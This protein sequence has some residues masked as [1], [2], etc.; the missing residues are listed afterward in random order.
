MT[1]QELQAERIKLIDA[2]IKSLQN[3]IEAIE[4]HHRAKLI[5]I[6]SDI[7]KLRAQKRKLQQDDH[8]QN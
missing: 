3:R 6:V 4:I 1:P 8:A 2:N 5:D 7:D